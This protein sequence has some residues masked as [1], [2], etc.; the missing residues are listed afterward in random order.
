[1]N[2]A[3]TILFLGVF[4]LFCCRD[5]PESPWSERIAQSF[6]TLH[7]DSIV[8][9]DEAKSKKWNYEQGLMLEAFFQMWKHSGDTMYFRYVKK[10]IDHY[11]TD[12][13]SILTYKLADYN[14]DNI[15]PGKAVVRMFRQTGDERYRKAA[16]VLRGQLR[17]QP[18]TL[19]GG[20]WH[21]KIYPFQMWLDGLYM[22][23]PFYTMYAN[24]FGE[25]QAYDDIAHQFLLIRENH[26][27]P[28]TGLYFH[29]WDESGQQRW[30]DPKTGCSPNLW[31][32]SIGW[33]A[34]ALVDV[35][36]LF[37]EDHPKRADLMTMFNDLAEHAWQA[38][39]TS[40]NLWYQIV[41]RKEQPGNYLEASAST[42]LTYAMARG[43]NLGYLP[44]R[45][46]KRAST[47]FD[48][49]IGNFVKVDAGVV[50]LHSVVKVGGL[51][52]DPYRDGSFEYYISEPTR[53]NDFKGYGPLLLAAIEVE[54][55]GRKETR[56]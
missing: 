12:D 34:M 16:G 43:A 54:K 17:E 36:E 53:I 10:N 27:D 5:A 8:Y 55:S 41:D 44:D 46:A 42:M 1:M 19:S 14:I 21:K 25:E 35:L 22:G 33:L 32:R 31:G 7:P 26:K 48:A 2:P 38:R 56:P 24:T 4:G 11:V 18:R 6:M 45:F 47:S 20:F 37:P 13:G 15:A 50:S 40:S 52:G 3:K 9:Q 49:I 29:G 28:R 23:E 30:A 39:D 51:G